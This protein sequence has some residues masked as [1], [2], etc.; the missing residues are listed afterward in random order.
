M[1]ATAAVPATA[2]ESIRTRFPALSGPTTRLDG[3]AGS[4]IPRQV[5]ESIAGY[6]GTR[7]ANLGG[8]FAES[9]AAT[10]LVKQARHR[11]AAFFGTAD[12]DEV[13]FGLNASTVNATMVAL[14]A[15][16]M[17]TG[18]EVVVSALDHDAPTLF[19]TLGLREGAVRIG[20]LH[21]NTGAEVDSALNA[22]ADLPG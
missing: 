18:D 4:L 19:E 16:T 9:L 20:F 13:G 2:V 1:P 14:A 10:R 3:P 6:L 15:A 21:Y 11:C 8:V 5:I 12:R 17:K 22:L 7:P